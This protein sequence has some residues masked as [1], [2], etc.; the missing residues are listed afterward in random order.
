[1]Q[2]K[3]SPYQYHALNP[4]K[5]MAAALQGLAGFSQG[6]AVGSANGPATALVP[7][8][9]MKTMVESTLMAPVVGSGIIPSRVQL[10]PATEGLDLRDRSLLNLPRYDIMQDPR[11]Y[12]SE[13]HRFAGLGK[14]PGA[15]DVPLPVGVSAPAPTVKAS[16]SR[17]SSAQVLS[18]RRTMAQERL[19]NPLPTAEQLD[20]QLAQVIR[21]VEAEF[22]QR[23]FEVG[24]LPTTWD[25]IYGELEST[26]R[27]IPLVRADYDK[28][29]AGCGKSGAVPGSEG[30]VSYAQ[31]C[32]QSKPLGKRVEWLEAKLD[33]IRML[34]K[35]HPQNNLWTPQQ[36]ARIAAVRAAAEARAAAIKAA[37]DA[38]S[39]SGGGGSGSSGGSSGGN[40]GSS[41][42][43]GGSGSTASTNSDPIIDGYENSQ[44]PVTSQLKT[45]SSMPTW[46]PY[47]AAVA[48]IGGY[49]WM[50]RS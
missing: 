46:L 8:G 37:A 42:S 34:I 41:G 17:T 27:S 7:A 20:L 29:R 4:R 35:R 38:G 23:G 45:T 36:E 44:L 9:S 14:L 48:L 33:A 24:P 26:S 6:V 22:R 43:S 40:T 21:E 16:L 49:F 1:M 2:G 15:L 32:E 3:L 28:M 19:R 11:R 39:G 13:V 25:G 5:R 12:N 18:A 30:A 31:W 50:R 47:A 10:V